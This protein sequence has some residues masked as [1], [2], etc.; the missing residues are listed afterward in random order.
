MGKI[1]S[2][3]KTEKDTIHF[4]D[5]I[6]EQGFAYQKLREHYIHST[7]LKFKKDKDLTLKI[8]SL[9]TELGE[10]LEK[11]EKRIKLDCELSN[12]SFRYFR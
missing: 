8:R 2:T 6:S 10:T 11:L 1:I 12:K 5:K 4:L 7:L 9:T 3:T